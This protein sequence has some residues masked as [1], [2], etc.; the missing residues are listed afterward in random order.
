MP[1]RK[2]SELNIGLNPP[3]R[4]HR[5][6]WTPWQHKVKWQMEQAKAVGHWSRYRELW[7]KL[8]RRH[9]K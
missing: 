9:L 8:Y 1:R 6:T 2:R 5:L 3:P 7:R 4:D